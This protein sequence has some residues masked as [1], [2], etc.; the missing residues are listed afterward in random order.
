MIETDDHHRRRLAR[1]TRA[2]LGLEHD[3]V[4]VILE[5][6]AERRLGPQILGRPGRRVGAEATGPDHGEIEMPRHHRDR[7][8]QGRRPVIRSTGR[9]SLD[10]LIGDH[11]CNRRSRQ[12][13]RQRAA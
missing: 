12:T 5:Q 11:G 8:A 6:R 3:D 1:G 9:G 2:G 10:R 7:I 4:A 13:Y